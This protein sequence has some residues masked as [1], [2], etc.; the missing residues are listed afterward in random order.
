MCDKIEDEI[1]DHELVQECME[2]DEEPSVSAGTLSI[3][4]DL[5]RSQKYLKEVENPVK[6]R[7]ILLDDEP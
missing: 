3:A 4:S 1:R 7:V 5:I 6:K 2:D